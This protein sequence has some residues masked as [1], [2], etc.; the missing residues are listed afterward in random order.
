MQTI[1]IFT[2]FSGYDSQMMGLINAAKKLKKFFVELV[3]WSDID[4]EVQ[5]VHNLA[6]P[7]DADKCHPDVTKINWNKIPYFDLLFYSSPCQSAS[8]SG[9][10][11]GFEKDS[12]TKSSLVWA[13]ESAIACKRPKWL[14]LENVEGYLDPQNE[15]TL[16]KWART[17]ASYGYVSR[18]KVLCSADFGVPQNRNRIFMISM[19]IDN[20]KEFKFQWPKGTKLT[21]KPEDLLEDIVDDE[22]YLNT[23][24]VNGYIDLLRNA[25]DGYRG[26]V[27]NKLGYPT[28]YFTRQFNRKISATVTPI[29]K[30]GAIPTLQTS[31]GSTSLPAFAGCRQEGLPCVVEVWEGEKGLKP[32]ALTGEKPCT[33]NPEA[34]KAASDRKRILSIID[35][36]KEGQYLRIRRLTPKECLRF[37]GVDDMYIDRMQ[38]PYEALAKEGYTEEQIT[39]LMTISGRRRKVSDYALYGRAGNSIVVNVLT[40]IFTSII[41]QYP[42]SFGDEYRGMTP[43]EIRAAKKRES[44]RRYYEKHREE[45]C[46]KCREYQRKKRMK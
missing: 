12:G 9:R 26:S 14:I 39:K 4:P 31:C 40:E 2:L 29:T 15:P 7:K 18:F 13:V 20:E 32:I 1:K 44:A 25:H 17:L 35:N 41:E 3:G 10:R 33:P 21:V 34:K 38:N 45:V 46:R 11:E 37:M 22:Y 27:N 16:R 5:R 28:K 42:N 8:R 43:E 23:E 19:S 24:M 30:S 36:I 6:F